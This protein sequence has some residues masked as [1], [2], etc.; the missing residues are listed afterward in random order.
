MLLCPSSRGHTAG[1]VA[2]PHLLLRPQGF[3]TASPA[4]ALEGNPEQEMGK[5][6]QRVW[7]RSQR[8]N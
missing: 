4:E 8:F 6:T 2:A 7:R 3:P 5:G 1:E